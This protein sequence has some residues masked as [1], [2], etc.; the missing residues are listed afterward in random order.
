MAAAKRATYV[1]FIATGFG[2]ASW[3][4]RIPQYK[5][6]L[7]L[8]ASQLGLLLLALAAG[9]V[10]ALP[11][12][13][14]LVARVGSRRTIVAMAV[15]AG[16]ALCIVAGGYELGVAVVGVGLFMFGMANGA[17]DVAMNVQGATVER[18]LGRAMLPRFH[19]GFSLG[20]VAGALVGVVAVAVGLP[21]TVHLAIVGILVA[22][23]TH[24]A[25]R[26]FLPDRG[27]RAHV[28]GVRGAL[29]PWRERRTLLIGVVVLAFAFAEGSG[30]DW[31]GVAMVEGHGTRVTFGILGFATFLGAMTVG[32]WL[33]PRL[34]DSY[35]RVLVLRALAV[36][37]VL[38]VALFAYG[39]N[40]EVAF[41]GV[42]LWGTGVSLGFPVGMSAGADEPGAAAAR[43][44]VIS[45]I[46][47]C[48]FLGGPPL[49]GFL[50][51]RYTV[52]H[53]L[54]AV[55]VA[56]AIACAVMAV[57]RPLASLAGD[58]GRVD[59]TARRADP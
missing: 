34:I 38:G 59:A 2:I 25:V 40:I 14:P 51:Q 43:V 17:W 26:A 47:Y 39:R 27:E 44:A 46:G 56:A 22:V 29:T 21:V 55:A 3:A 20:T 15:L 19:A 36:V 12:C 30:N 13:G 57:V 33:G 10:I 16:V 31:I 58:D 49:I 32:R 6:R 48:A 5:T 7:G 53:A 28:T 9:S 18:Q 45:S 11:L 23:L 35:G 54:L 41:V 8:D 52:A 50:G 1:A 24:R 37:M 4:S 42:T